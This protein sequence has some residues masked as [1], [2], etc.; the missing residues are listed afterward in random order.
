M[1]TNI[2]HI[3]HIEVP[4][5][6]LLWEDKVDRTYLAQ[7]TKVPQRLL[8][9][10]IESHPRELLECTTI[11]QV[12]DTLCD[13]FYPPPTS[14]TS[15]TPLDPTIDNRDSSTTTIHFHIPTTSYTFDPWD[16]LANLI[17][18]TNDDESLIDQLN[19]LREKVG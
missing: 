4:F 1:S 9:P 15:T 13:H 12:L 5:I 8:K 19:Q 17:E 10:Y 6:D 2:I 7:Q 16:I 11:N 3:P 18:N 14:T